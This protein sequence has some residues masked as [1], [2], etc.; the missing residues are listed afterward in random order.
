MTAVTLFMGD[1]P[2]IYET[3]SGENIYI[4]VTGVCNDSVR[5]RVAGPADWGITAYYAVPVETGEAVPIH[6][7]VVEL[8]GVQ[9]AD[10][11]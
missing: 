8:A 5:L 11:V 7:E 10:I 4:E 3:G 1:T 6:G 2:T 9:T